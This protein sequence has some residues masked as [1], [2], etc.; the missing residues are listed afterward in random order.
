[1]PSFMGNTM[2]LVLATVSIL[3]LTNVDTDQSKATDSVECADSPDNEQLVGTKTSTLN[4][5]TVV[6]SE[7]AVYLNSLIDLDGPLEFRP[8]GTNAGDLELTSTRGQ[9]S[10]ITTGLSVNGKM[11][12]SGTVLMDDGTW[13]DQV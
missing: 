2:E 6:K 7:D 12:L 1:M 5:Q 3:C 10:Q 11:P 8:T 4:F 9:V 13:A